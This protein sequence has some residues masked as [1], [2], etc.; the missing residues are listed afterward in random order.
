MAKTSEGLALSK[1]KESSWF[2][3]K[4]LLI[5]LSSIFTNLA[6]YMYLLTQSWLVVRLFNLDSYLGI[7]LMVATIPRVVLMT[8]GGVVADRISRSK[9]MFCCNILRSFI[10]IIM[11]ILLLCGYLKIN[12]LL[13][14]VLLF[15]ILDAFFW[16]ANSSIL[17]FIVN[18]NGLGK[19]NSI[20]YIVNQASIIAGPMIAGLIISMGSIEIA[21]I[22]ISV[23]LL[24]GGVL[25]YPVRISKI[26][27][28]KKKTS[29]FQD[30]V[31]GLKY[32]TNTPFLYTLILVNSV[33]SFLLIGPINTSI[34]LIV[35]RLHGSPI[36]LSFLESSLAVGMIL[37]G[38]ILSW[39]SLKKKR[40]TMII[41]SAFFMGISV[42]LL[43]QVGLLWQGMFLLCF[44]GFF[45]SLSGVLLMTVIQ[46]RVDSQ[47]IGRVMSLISTSTQ[48][49]VPLAYGIVALILSF[50]ISIFQILLVSGS[51]ISVVMIIVFLTAKELREI[52]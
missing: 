32:V 48:G 17:P 25:V 35:D 47:K 37:G 12:Y 16:P 10:V 11:T 46:E 41:I 52:R 15:G 50:N 2:N 8:I 24:L 14:F 20:F 13:V 51:L 33:I 38:L 7:V 3:S 31:Q 18:E 29:P 22:T 49:L 28:E 30:L 34:P 21:F 39:I 27:Q 9:I 42:F 4:F 40:G 23:F 44:L 26:N 6:N 5:C 1:E 36:E 19:A 43:S 45:M